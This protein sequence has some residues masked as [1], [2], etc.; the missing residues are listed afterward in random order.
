MRLYI[1]ERTDSVGYDEYDS[2]VVAALSES[3][4][5]YEATELW[6][7]YDPVTVKFIGIADS[8]EPGVIHSSFNA[9]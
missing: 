1:V 7:K 5:K 6:S 2:C 4:A 8:K 9:G 3:D